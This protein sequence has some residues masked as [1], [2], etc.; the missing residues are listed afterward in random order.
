MTSIPMPNMAA[1]NLVQA[2][3][4]NI[5]EAPTSKVMPYITLEITHG[6]TL[7][8]KSTNNYPIA[9]NFHDSSGIKENEG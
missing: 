4:T 2:H 5:T 1:I 6:F 8:K 7:P 9:S 3:W